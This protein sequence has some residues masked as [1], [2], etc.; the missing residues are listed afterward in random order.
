[1]QSVMTQMWSVWMDCLKGIA[2]KMC[3]AV[4]S[5]TGEHLQLSS[6]SKS[7]IMNVATAVGRVKFRI[8]LCIVVPNFP[9]SILLSSS[10]LF[11][12]IFVIHFVL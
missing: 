4:E 11:G 10:V 9:L 3:R 5:K 2:N 1:M 8:K 12:S 6:T 7:R